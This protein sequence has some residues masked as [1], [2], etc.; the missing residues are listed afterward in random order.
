MNVCELNDIFGDKI[1][2]LQPDP[3]GPVLDAAHLFLRMSLDYCTDAGEP[4]IGNFEIPG[5]NIKIDG[6]YL[7]EDNQEFHI[8]SLLYFDEPSPE[9]I[10]T[11]EQFE[12]A[13]EG[14]LNFV[15]QAFQVTSDVPTSSELGEMVQELYDDVSAG[16][17]TVVDFFSNVRFPTDL[18]TTLIFRSNSMPALYHDAAEIS[19]AIETEDSAS[20]VVLFKKKYGK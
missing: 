16:Y 1:S 20:H 19:E 15:K 7:D 9:Q 6:Y 13:K 4:V 17:S 11:E 14:V 8:L 12:I 2:K 5:R 10:V 18:P 3:D